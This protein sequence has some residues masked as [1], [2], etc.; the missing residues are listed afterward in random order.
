[1][2][3]GSIRRID[4]LGRIVIPKNIRQ[5]LKIRPE[6]NLKI[7]IKEDKIV[8]EK[9]SEMSREIEI[10]KA[11]AKTIK[12][13]IKAEVIVTDKERVIIGESKLKKE[14]PEKIT[15]IIRKRNKITITK[16]N[17]NIYINPIIINGDAIGSI[18][19][20]T[21]K[22]I[23]YLITNTVDTMTRFLIKYIE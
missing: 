10:E 18:I 5:E 8:I 13:I 16:N 11:I 4:E 19:V 9:Y 23:D 22:E 12:E 21:N 14:L 20:I 6:D 7:Y 17:K 1:M 2:N 15:S 3:I